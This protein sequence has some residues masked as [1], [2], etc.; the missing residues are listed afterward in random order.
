MLM[1]G[2]TAVRAL[3]GIAA[4]LGLATS[5]VAAQSPADAQSRAQFAWRTGIAHL[6]VPHEGCF[7]AAYPAE[8]WSDVACVA[9]PD[10]P[11][12]PGQNR[13][14]WFAGVGAGAGIDY[15]A[16]SAGLT[17]AAVGSFPT[18]TGVTTEIGKRKK[19]NVYSI[20]L[21]SQYFAS[22]TCSGAAIPAKCQGWEQFIYSNT[23]KAFLEYWL[24]N[25]LAI[26][27]VGW[28]PLGPD[29]YLSGAAVQV[30]TQVI[31]QLAFLGLSA[32]AVAGGIDT[33][34][35]TT[36]TNAYSTTGQDSVVG[37][38]GFWKGTE[39]NIVGD[40]S[41]ANAS[42]N[43][44][45]TVTVK[46]ALTDGSTAAPVCSGDTGTTSETNNLKVGACKTASGTPPS[47]TFTESH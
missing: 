6:P 18:V 38:A 24:I 44:G 34:T 10:I 36:A 47:V 41:G 29:C 27:P 7:T 3:V 22:P 28:K 13:R 23:G 43:I 8:S 12:I 15:T 31:A 11:Y 9:A 2:S 20:Q 19:P 4:A 42:F 40:G 45:S 5:V 39:Y 33:L 21:N 17:S 35:F 25:Y 37:L 16:V 1:F 26:C 46:I 32:Q 14:G 30:P